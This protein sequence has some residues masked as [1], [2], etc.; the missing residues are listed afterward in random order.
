MPEKTI[1]VKDLAPGRA[2]AEVFL[3]TEARLAQAKNGPFWSLV[4]EDATGAVEAKIW[5]P[6]AQNHPDLK[7]GCFARVEGQVQTYRDK[8]QIGVERLE[9]LTGDQIPD[10]CHFV[11]TS[12]RPPAL[13]LADLDELLKTHVAHA[14]WRRFCRKV[15]ADEAIR[16][17]L[18]GAVGA[19]AI[20]HAYVGGLLEHSLAVCR[21]C[22]AACDIHPR[23]DRDTLLCA[24]AFHDLG[25]A[26]EL[27]SA[28]A[29]DYTDTGRLLG[30]VILGLEILEPFLKKT[31]DLDPELALHFKHILVSHHGENAFG[32]PKRP[33]T[34][35]AFVLHFAD[36]LDAKVNQA[37]GAFA[38]EAGDGD[39][40]P[41]QRTLDRYLF[42]PRRT[43][44]PVENSRDEAANG[45]AEAKG[46]RQ[47][48]LL[49]KA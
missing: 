5:S 6:L 37:F 10:L 7:P 27:T 30:H 16:T 26:W 39:W 2:V 1:F 25:K 34:P 45:P 19:K 46:P 24:A 33:K 20:H 40:S 11:A 36:N 49:S 8:S 47:C 23:L 31:R 29:R 43:A 22:L 13:L 38:E 15:L 42:N 14:P 18:L 9:V 21:V 41:F 32:A 3:L 44:R 48:S 4:L 12:A 17:R 28:P 35:E